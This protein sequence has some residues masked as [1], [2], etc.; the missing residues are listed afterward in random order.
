M[1]RAVYETIT[2]LLLLL[3]TVRSTGV[4]PKKIIYVDKVNGTLRP[5]FWQ[6]KAESSSTEVTLDGVNLHKS[7]VVAVK[8]KTKSKELQESTAD[9]PH[10]QQCPTWFFTDSTSNGTCRCGD[11][12]HDTVQCNNST[13]EASILNCYCM[14]Y[15]KSTGPVVGACFYNC[16][17]P[18]LKNELRRFHKLYHLL[19]PNVTQLNNFMC[20]YFNR[21]GQ[22]CGKCKENHNIPLYSYDL[23]CV[24]CSTSPFNWIK[25]ILAAFLPLTVF[26][27]L[28]MGCRLSATSPKLL[29][30]VFFSQSFA[31]GGN[32]CAVLEVT[33]LYPILAKLARVVL[34]LYG[35][36]NLDFF[37]TLL[38]HICVKIDTLQALALDYAI[39]FY[40][41]ILLVVT[42]ILIQVHICNFRVI[43][44]MCRPF[45]RCTEHFRSQWNVGTSIVEAFATFLLLSY[46]KLLSVSF[47]L[48]VPI[49]VYNVNGSLVGLYLFY[50]ATIE[51]FGKEHLPYGVLAVFVLLVFIL[52]PLLLLLL[53]PMRC[54]QRCLG[55]CR[56]RWHAL[57]IFIDAFQGCYKDGTNGTRDCRYFAAAFL[58]ARILLC[59]AFALN[60]TGMFYVAALFL[61][62][63]LA[64]AIV[65]VK[66]Y[67]PRFSTYNVVDSVIVLI[68]ALWCATATCIV[69][70][71]L[72]AHSWLKF[73]VPLAFAVVLL[74]L[75][76][77]SFVTLHW[78]C[79]R[80]QCGQVMG[81][82]CKWIGERHRQMGA[83]GSEELLP[84]RLINPDE[85]EKSLMNPVTVQVEENMSDDANAEF[86]T[87]SY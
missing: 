63:P 1:A 86:K 45:R 74:P 6:D 70:A 87:A 84:D 66:P 46:L 72:E 31:K 73:F 59:I 22:L 61:L 37:R 57:P 58:L 27:V 60:Q 4:Q 17:N 44:L 52:F 69:I 28:V 26:F 16:M 21:K 32:V 15:N 41:L 81:R 18:T 20:G 50:D 10:D 54:F 76:Y 36:W 29:A 25:Y 49:H 9:A 42:Y 71:G 40:P 67:K 5:S 85:Y 75:F 24:Q 51:Y 83:A 7:T 39:A 38:P 35:F 8:H 62:I 56:V 14:T 65:I 11:D 13:K 23:K 33:K 64:M 53:Y 80:R 19:P 68:M 43:R 78:M 12:V 3:T 77:I 55:C 2:W 34:A 48:L 79:S 30:F 82:V 47:D